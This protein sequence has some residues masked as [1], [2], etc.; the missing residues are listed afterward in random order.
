MGA[1]E[2]NKKRKKSIKKYIKRY[3]KNRL[4]KIEE[5]MARIKQFASP[6]N[7]NKPK[8]DPIK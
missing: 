8:L 6:A 3:I 4:Q 1:L 5:K 7:K 2:K